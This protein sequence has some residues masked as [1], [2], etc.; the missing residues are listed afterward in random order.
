VKTHTLVLQLGKEENGKLYVRDTSTG[1]V[2]LVPNPGT[3][4]K[5]DVLAQVR[6]PAGAWR[7]K[8]VLDL[9]TKDLSRITINHPGDA[10]A[11]VTL[12]QADNTWTVLAGKERIQPEPILINQMIEA[13]GKLEAQEF[14]GDIPSPLLALAGM[15]A[16][17]DSSWSSSL[18]NLGWVK[19]LGR[20]SLD[21]V[22]GLGTPRL[23]ITLTFST[24][25]QSP[26]T[27]LLGKATP[28]GT[29]IY[30]RLA[31]DPTIFVVNPTLLKTLDLDVLALVPQTLWDL[32]PTAIDSVRIVKQG[33]PAFELLRKD[34]G[35][36]L[37]GPGDAS[38][39]T[40][41]VNKLVPLLAHLHCERYQALDAKD[42]APFGLDKPESTMTLK[43]H[44]PG[45]PGT[46]EHVLEIGK[47]VGTRGDHYARVDNSSRVFVL[48]TPSVQTLTRG[49]LDLVDRQV[50][51]FDPTSAQAFK[52]SD[53]A[54]ALEIVRREDRW[55]ITKPVEEAAD[56]KELET[57]WKTLGNLRAVRVAA[58]SP[59]ELKEYGLDAPLATI[60]LDL[61]P[62]QKPNQLVLKI[63]KPVAEATGEHFAQVVGHPAVVV[64]PAGV[65]R[66]LRAAPLAFR[67]RVLTKLPG[68]DTLRLER[69]RRKATFAL[70]KDS[71]MLT[72]PLRAEA[73]T[74]LL[75]DFL[76]ALSSLHADELVQD[77]PTADDLKKYG[78]DSPLVRYQVLDKGKEL[79]DL[80][81]GGV[82][83]NSGR[84]YA[85]IGKRELV[86]LLDPKLSTMVLEEFRPRTV[87]DMPLDAAEVNQVR[88]SWAKSP[89]TLSRV[90]SNWQVSDKPKTPVNAKAVDDMLA[91]LAGL[92]LER[93]VIDKDADLQLYGLK[94]P[95]L[96]L[97]A[98]T[99][100]GQWGLHIGSRVGE[101]KARYAQLDQPGKTDVFLI[102]EADASRIVK[103][104]DAFVEK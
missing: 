49:F 42:M 87:W 5:E 56:E 12:E 59:T 8:Q 80:Q 53:A 98:K 35:W 95:E 36:K 85:R 73:N 19:M 79:L 46:A 55:V 68:F 24:P 37:S 23:S 78:L 28:S 67:D 92:K 21:F 97:L 1:R 11:G 72:E 4:G 69:D 104:L 77:K 74:T 86:F 39:E 61:S 58:L 52:R 50:L 15:F 31:D 40:T 38:A 26:Q 22:Y 57:L 33:Q 6:R 103:E 7:A 93:Y 30:A 25:K 29:G 65:I 47:P 81:V 27:L 13:V 66:T 18:G 60:T 99:N 44:Q 3:G 63:G 14:V 100:T 91:A 102:A 48:A 32:E 41:E 101:S 90:R 16:G 45:K 84:R 34:A 17:M 54:G 75:D 94:T 2:S 70:G 10:A 62:D 9:D 71:W 20:D 76:T 43:F 64:L 51:K 82:E 83:K 96:T 88:F 89:F